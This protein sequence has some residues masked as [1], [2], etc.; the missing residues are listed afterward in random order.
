MCKRRLEE[1]L[2]RSYCHM[3]ARLASIQE[4]NAL[5][6]EPYAKPTEMSTFHIE[7]YTVASDRT[8]QK[9]KHYTESKAFSSPD[10]RNKP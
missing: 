10:S 4:L 5:L 1:E 2:I 9:E 6:Q 8:L 3:F 7:G